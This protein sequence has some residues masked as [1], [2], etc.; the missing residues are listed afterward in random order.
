MYWLS[1]KKKLRRLKGAKFGEYGCSPYSLVFGQKTRTSA[2]EYHDLWL[3]FSPSLEFLTN[4]FAQ[5]AHNFK[6]LFLIGRTTLWQELMMKKTVSKL[7]IFDL[8][9]FF[10]S[11]L[12]GTLP[13]EW[14]GFGFSVISISPYSSPITRCE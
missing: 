14:L 5:S 9:W 10:R 7:C 1:K 13:L 12:L 11:W 4:Y 2:G 8:M 6:A 3:V